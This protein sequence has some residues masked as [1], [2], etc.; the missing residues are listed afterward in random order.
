MENKFN[1]REVSEVFKQCNNLL[2]LLSWVQG[3][4]H[5]NLDDDQHKADN[6]WFGKVDQKIFTFKHSVHNYLRENEKVMARRSGISKKT[7]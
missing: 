6:F 1:I 3:E 4:Y 7:K 2:K 5:V